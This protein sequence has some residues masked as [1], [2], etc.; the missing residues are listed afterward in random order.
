LDRK[1]VEEEQN[2]I[3]E[4]LQEACRKEEQAAQE[5]A[6]ALAAAKVARGDA[7]R[8]ELMRQREEARLRELAMREEQARIAQ[9]QEAKRQEEARKR[10]EEARVQAKIRKMGI[11][12]AGFRWIKQAHGYRC[13][14]GSHFLNNDVLGIN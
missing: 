1:R 7:E 14:G 2:A 3:E 6:R 8:N 11:C 5:V 13:A 9:L 12:P 4:D 10:K